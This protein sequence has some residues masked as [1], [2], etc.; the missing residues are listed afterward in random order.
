MELRKYIP[1]WHKSRAA[2]EQQPLDFAAGSVRIPG[3]EA[4]FDA[5]RAHN[6]DVRGNEVAEMAASRHHAI[7]EEARD[8]LIPHVQESIAQ[9]CLSTPRSLIWN[10]TANILRQ[11]PARFDVVRKEKSSG[12][13]GVASE[14]SFLPHWKFTW[15]EQSEHYGTEQ[16]VEIYAIRH[17]KR[18]L[19]DGELKQVLGFIHSG[20]SGKVPQSMLGVQPQR[21]WLPYYLGDDIKEAAIER[22]LLEADTLHV[23]MSNKVLGPDENQKLFDFTVDNPIGYFLQPEQRSEI[24]G[25]VAEHWKKGNS[26]RGQPDIHDI[27]ECLRSQYITQDIDENFRKLASINAFLTDP[28]PH[29]NILPAS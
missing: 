8:A 16:T 4:V 20:F 25:I 27:E 19:A 15:N 26:L 29:P 11:N 22:S 3:R 18:D 17:W 7:T 28:V 1:R 23:T 12:N 6:D 13:P 10:E 14:Y 21:R 5:I 9:E 24:V 2:V